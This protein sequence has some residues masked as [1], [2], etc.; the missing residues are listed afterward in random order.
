MSELLIWAPA[1]ALWGGAAACA[2][3]FP[4]NLVK[5]HER[6]AAGWVLLGGRLT[7]AALILTLTTGVW[8]GA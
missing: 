5:G 4:L 1:A 7:L 3:M 2:V 6:L 8:S